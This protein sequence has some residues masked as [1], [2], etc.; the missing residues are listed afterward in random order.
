MYEL[1]GDAFASDVPTTLRRSK[2]DCPPRARARAPLL[3][4]AQAPAPPAAL[5]ARAPNSPLPLSAG[6][7]APPAALVARA[8]R[9]PLLLVGLP[10][11]CALEP[12]TPAVLARRRQASTC[13]Q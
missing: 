7:P 12:Y 1:D 5:V 10:R 2:A 9:Y 11:N 4:V 3:L 13:V 6:G 8:P